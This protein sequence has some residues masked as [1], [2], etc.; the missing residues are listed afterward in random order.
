[1][2]AIWRTA[3]VIG[4][5][6][7]A[8]GAQSAAG[9]DQYPPYAQQQQQIGCGGQASGFTSS[10]QQHQNRTRLSN[11][12]VALL[13]STEQARQAIARGDRQAAIKQIDQAL[14]NA[15]QARNMS[16]I[17]GRGNVVPI[18]TEYAQASVIG[19]IAT[20][21]NAGGIQAAGAPA[22]QEVVGQY[23]SVA[24]DLPMAEQHLQAARTA[25]LNNDVSAADSALKAVEDGVI[26]LRVES[27]L[28]LV[29]ARENLAL[30]RDMISQGNSLAAQAPLR[31][32]INALAQYSGPRGRQA[33]RL[34]MQIASLANNLPANQQ[35]A[36]GQ[37]DQ[38]W[39]VLADWTGNVQQQQ[40]PIG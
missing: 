9:Q 12:A 31:E 33:E 21:R 26:M 1:M 37:I 5:S 4:A 7:L 25:L 6:A 39:N 10:S 19:P 23:T 13:G 35:T 24:L 29:Q 8:L 28:P 16:S 17:Q 14:Q 30:A 20:S 11:A 3:Y 27:D 36:A 40:P 34:Q 38:W 2:F 18:Y 15:R 22:V 32:A